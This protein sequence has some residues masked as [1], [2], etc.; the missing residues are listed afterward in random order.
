MMRELPARIQIRRL[1]HR[2]LHPTIL[3]NVAAPLAAYQVL[4]NHG[5]PTLDALLA[6]AVFPLAAIML[7][8]LRTGQLDAFGV[9]SLVAIAFG[10]GGGLLF[11]DPRYLLVKDSAVTGLFGLGCLLSLP[12]S[13]PLIHLIGRPFVAGTDRAAM[14]RY[15]ATLLVPGTLS[16][17][18]RLTLIWG[19][20]LVAEAS[21]RVGLVMV[22]P[23]SLMVIGSPLLA[24]AIFGPLA[25]WTVRQGRWST[26]SSPVVAH[27]Q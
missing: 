8:A 19:L 1:G 27:A 13:R 18:R 12:T 4:T 20:A 21:I 2:L 3:L 22:L 9:L 14:E 11:R 15:D 17:V 25:I 26:P 23:P 6:A 7:A 24:I 5:I 16:R 10:V